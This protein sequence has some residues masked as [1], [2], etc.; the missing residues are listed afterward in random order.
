MAKRVIAQFPIPLVGSQSPSRV[1][2]QTVQDWRK[3]SQHLRVVKPGRTSGASW[4]DE[5]VSR[6][7]NFTL[8]ESCA[9]KYDVGWWKRFEY[10]SDW[11]GWWVDC[12]GCGEFYRC[13]MYYAEETARKVL[14]PR[15][16]NPI[17]Q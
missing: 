14:L 16:Q 1:T 13:N 4:L 17:P 9:R 7:K 10:V 6:R 2:S 12:D 8:C 11:I 3:R 5:F 15:F